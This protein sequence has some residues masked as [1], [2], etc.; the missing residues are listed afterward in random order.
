[1]AKGSKFAVN[2]FSMRERGG[3]KRRGEGLTSLKDEFANTIDNG[4]FPRPL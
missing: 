2:P 1:M 3:A 4:V